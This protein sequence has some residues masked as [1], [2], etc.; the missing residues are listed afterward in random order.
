MGTGYRPTD[1]SRD[2]PRDGRSAGGA[3]FGLPARPVL[4]ILVALLALVAAGPAAAEQ[5]PQDVVAPETAIT[6]AP[7]HFSRETTPS[8]EFSAD[9]PDPSSGASG[10]ECRLDD[11]SW[12]V[13]ESG[14]SFVA[15]EGEHEL[16]VR[17]L[18]LAG[19]ADASPATHSWLVDRTPPEISIGSPAV[20][21]HFR[22][23][24]GSKSYSCSDPPAG[25]PPAVASGVAG[26]SDS[27]FNNDLG[28]GPK[29]FVV[30]ARDRA[31]NEASVE[32]AYVIDPVD[33]GAFVK[34]QGPIAYYRMGEPVGSALMRDSSGNGHD[35]RYQND[36]ATGG[37]PA[38]AC[39]R[40]PQPP[41]ACELAAQGRDYAAHFPAR[42]GHGYANGIAA[43]TGG[44]T[45]E[46][47]VR[48]AE[49]GE[50]M[51]AGH[52]GGGQLFISGGKLALRQVRDTVTGGGPTLAPG[53]G[54]TSQRPGTAA[55]RAST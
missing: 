30:S 40:R 50:M 4:P 31:G 25:G 1:G 47:W 54:G 48:P 27:G 37:A 3:G 35:G 55:G 11:G 6:A 34:S 16:A 10:F 22:L 26:C 42:D 19:N 5:P 49:A 52:G 32:R 33:Y 46:A 53:R 23:H 39:E 18:D 17:A 45:L 21:Q 20:K 51:I 12:S 8:F 38:I 24:Q 41:R 28:L 44:Y 9:D 43:P 13:C 14:D 15:A 29:L 36:I 7:D 2:F